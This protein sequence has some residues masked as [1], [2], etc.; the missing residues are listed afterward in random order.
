VFIRPEKICDCFFVFADRADR[1][2]GGEV[3]A[4]R[5]FRRLAGRGSLQRRTS[6][7]AA[8]HPDALVRVYARGRFA[9]AGIFAV[10]SWIVIKE[11]NAPRYTRYDYTAWAGQSAS[12][13]LSRWA[14]SAVRRKRSSRPDGEAADRMI[15]KIRAAV[16]GYQ[17]HSYGDYR[18][19][20][21]P[22]SN[23]FVTAVLAAVPELQTRCRRTATARTFLT[24]ATCSTDAV[25]NGGP[26]HARWLSGPDDRLGRR[27]R[28]QLSGRGVGI[29]L[30]RPA[31]KLPG[32]GRVGFGY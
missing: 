31:V 16:E 17:L 10:H 2:I 32:L 28:D 19:W 9:G 27:Y 3:P 14:C 5:S 23:T 29:D 20:P 24:M 21:G 13:D 11:R 26:H 1:S 25:G 7:P 4:R 30:R 6:A 15:P 18:A 12:T 22:N 8:G